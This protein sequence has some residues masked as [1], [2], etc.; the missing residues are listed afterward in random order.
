VSS[1]KIR[2]FVGKIKSKYIARVGRIKG[3]WLGS[4]IK[5]KSES[6]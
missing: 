3:V 2:V 4:E 1:E 5:I 6:S